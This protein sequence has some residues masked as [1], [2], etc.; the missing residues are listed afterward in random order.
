ME[1]KRRRATGSLA[2][3]FG[4]APNKKNLQNSQWLQFVGS[5]AV[6][7]NFWAAV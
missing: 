4:S 5:F 7:P 3:I 2:R 6:A 1:R